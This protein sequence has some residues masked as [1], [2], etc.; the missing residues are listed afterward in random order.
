MSDEWITRTKAQGY[1]SSFTVSLN[2]LRTNQWQTQQNCRC[3]QR[4]LFPLGKIFS[5]LSCLEEGPCL[6]E[7]PFSP[8]LDLR[9]A[10]WFLKALPLYML[11][12]SIVIH[13]TLWQ[14][15]SSY[16]PISSN[17]HPMSTQHGPSQRDTCRLLAHITAPC[18]AVN[19]VKCSLF[20]APAIEV[21]KIVGRSCH[22]CIHTQEGI[23]VIITSPEG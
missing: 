3:N 10:N 5:T 4:S 23:Q 9:G 15:I 7:R 21:R 6:E 14:E 12:P 1:N 8:I 18:L 20:I 22:A 13:A 11:R 19:S 17:S 2:I 16:C